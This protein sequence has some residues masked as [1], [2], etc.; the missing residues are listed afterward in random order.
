M[1]Y[2][3][4]GPTIFI[5]KIP[6]EAILFRPKWTIWRHKNDDEFAW[7]RSLGNLDFLCFDRTEIQGNL[8]LNE[9]AEQIWTAIIAGGITLFNNATAQIGVGDSAV[10]E[11]DTQTD[12]QGAASYKGM[13][14]TYPLLSGTGND[15]VEFQSVF[16]SAEGNQAWNEFTVRNG[17]TALKNL[18]R[19][20]S[21]QG[22]K[23]SGQTWTIKISIQA[24]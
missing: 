21:A 6:K 5:P 20:V 11:A 24:T 15:T 22:T 2:L 10:A 17:A 9:G 1:E 23:S 7:A 8:L 14:V 3:A 16:G 13:D 19:K 4:H 18:N 12:L